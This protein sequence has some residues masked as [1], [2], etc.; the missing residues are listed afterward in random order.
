[1]R[2]K[3]S[4]RYKPLTDAAPAIEALD[5]C[6]RVVESRGVE[7]FREVCRRDLEGIVAKWKHGTYLSG[8]QT[9]W[10]K[11]KNPEYSQAIG[12]W[13]QFERRQRRPVQRVPS[14]FSKASVASN[15]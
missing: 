10:I 6:T 5:C 12:R 8:D 11:I 1:M 9:S 14:E 4:D 7:L 2:H 13:E 3:D 15:R